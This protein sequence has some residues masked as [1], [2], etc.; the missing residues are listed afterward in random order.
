MATLKPT[1][2]GFTLIELMIAV[3]VV[4]ILAAIAYPSYTEYVAR[5]KRSECKSALLRVAQFQ[6][7]FYTANNS[8]TSDLSGALL[9][10]GGTS[11][12]GEST[13][14][15]ACTIAITPTNA[16]ATPTQ[17]YALTATPQSNYK[18]KQCGLLTL[19]NTQ[20]KG[21][22]ANGSV[23]GTVDLCWQR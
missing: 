9:T 23:T 3:A 12:S 6:E 13:N 15:S 20:R 10:S 17:T 22:A 8:Y 14:S 7:R 11:Y 16:P 5:G 4:G 19:D 21:V 2:R 1:Q 18:D